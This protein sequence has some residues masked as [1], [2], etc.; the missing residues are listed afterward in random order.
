MH[1]RIQVY[2]D[3]EYSD[4]EIEKFTTDIIEYIENELNPYTCQI[5]AIA[6]ES[7][8]SESVVAEFP[9]EVCGKNG[10]SICEDFYPIGS[11]CFCGIDNDV[12]ICSFCGTVFNEF[13]GTGDI[14]NGCLPK[15]NI[16]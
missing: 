9:C 8:G 2:C 1:F 3:S 6:Y 14:C 15:D 4:D 16:Q 12:K 13:G 5:D 7:K 11:C 10:V